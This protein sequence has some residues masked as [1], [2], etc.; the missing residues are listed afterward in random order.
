MVGFRPALGPPR[1][2]HR[3]Q[4]RSAGGGLN[5]EL[6]SA[7]EELVEAFAETPERSTP[8]PN[9]GNW[10]PDARWAA[11][12]MR[13]WRAE[14]LGR[15]TSRSAWSWTIAVFLARRLGHSK[16]SVT[17]DTY[18]HLMKGTDAA[19]ALAIE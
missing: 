16:A 10:L 11:V 12:T 14:P 6:V 4:R 17:L 1:A 8:M 2:R 15:L 9:P 3:S 13:R 7:S 5:G 18:G 19:A